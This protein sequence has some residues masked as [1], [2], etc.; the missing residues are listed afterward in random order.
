MSAQP[1]DPKKL[2]DYREAIERAQ[3]PDK[4]RRQY[5]IY[6]WGNI[7]DLLADR[8]YHAGRVAELAASLTAWIA[9]A[10]EVENDAAV[11]R[12]EAS[13]LRARVEQAENAMAEE[14]ARAFAMQ[15]ERD[16]YAADNE[17]WRSEAL[18]LRARV[19]VNAE[20][21]RRTS[22][23]TAHVETWLRANG[24]APS[25]RETGWKGYSDG[26]TAT[27]QTWRVATPDARGVSL[28]YPERA[29]ATA[30]NVNTIAYHFGRNGLDILGEMAAI[31][32]RERSHGLPHADA[33]G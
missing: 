22:V 24:W 6:G 28:E 26:T 14:T 29:T 17:A 2:A 31:T 7:Q 1:M 33:S 19:R 10:E 16:E 15:H 21:V 12:R 11:L 27:T 9:R 18:R 8:D 32:V 23:T 20:D 3:H 25:E 5:P 30:D 4:H 13:R